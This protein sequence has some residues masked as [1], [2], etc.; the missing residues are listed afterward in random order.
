MLRTPHGD[1]A[2]SVAVTPAFK[3]EATPALRC[4]AAMSQRVPPPPAADTPRHAHA[5]L[6]CRQVPG[7]A[8]LPRQMPIAEALYRNVGAGAYT[9]TLKVQ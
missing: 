9:H 1:F 6:R 4:H 2:A 5:R 3:R 8:K 7:W